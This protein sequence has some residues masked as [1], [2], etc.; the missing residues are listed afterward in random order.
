MD[1]DISNSEEPLWPAFVARMKREAPNLRPDEHDEKWK[2]LYAVY[3]M[4]YAACLEILKVELEK[5][6]DPVADLKS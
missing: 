2:N 4:G 5:V 6:R 1:D 3:V